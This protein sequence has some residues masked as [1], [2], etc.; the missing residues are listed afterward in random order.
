MRTNKIGKIAVGVSGHKQSKFN[1]SHDV[2]NTMNM[3]EVRPLIVKEM[4]PH[5]SIGIKKDNLIMTAPLNVFTYG[6]IDYETISHF[7]PEEKIFPRIGSFLSGEATACPNDPNGWESV[8]ETKPSTIAGILA[9]YMLIG[10]KLNV[11]SSLDP[12]D[13]DDDEQ[14]SQ[15]FFDGQ[16]DVQN[17]YKFKPIDLRDGLASPAKSLYV[18][19]I[20]DEGLLQYGIVGSISEPGTNPNGESKYF[21][22][23]EKAYLW[24]NLTRLNVLIQEKNAKAQ[25]SRAGLL[26]SNY[27]AHMLDRKLR[28]APEYG[29]DHDLWVPLS[30][31]VADA[32]G[33]YETYN[34]GKRWLD[35]QASKLETGDGS[36]VPTDIVSPENADVVIPY[37]YEHDGKTYL[38]F[39]C[40]RL[41]DAGKRFFSLLK[42]CEMPTDIGCVRPVNCEKLLAVYMAYFESFGLQTTDAVQNH[43]F[44]RLIEAMRNDMYWLEPQNSVLACRDNLCDASLT[45][46]LDAYNLETNH[47]IPA[48]LCLFDMWLTDGSDFASIH[49]N[50]AVG[51]LPDGSSIPSTLYELNKFVHSPT[52]G[53]NNGQF[54]LPSNAMPHFS[55]NA[56]EGTLGSL[57]Q[58]ASAVH[59]PLDERLL[60]KLA[61][62]TNR[63]SILGHDIEKTLKA[64]GYGEV[65]NAFGCE[66]IGKTSTRL[67][68]SQ[69]P[70]LADTYDGVNGKELGDIG[71]KSITYDDSQRLTYETRNGGY[72]IT[73]C[74]IRPVS[75][76]SQSVDCE[77][78]DYER[79]DVYVPEF[80]GLGYE[81]TPMS[82]FFN[83]ARC[84]SLDGVLSDP[85]CETFGVVP[86]DSHRKVTRDVML[87]GFAL[88]SVRNTFSPYHLSRFTSL[89]DHTKVTE[90]QDGLADF[91]AL[92]IGMDKPLVLRDIPRCGLWTRSPYRYEWLCQLQ[93]IFSNS[94]VSNFDSNLNT[95][96]Y[97]DFGSN[98]FIF[99]EDNF[100]IH[101]HV[102]GYYNAPM[103]PIEVSYDSFEEDKG[104]NGSETKA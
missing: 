1:I 43:P 50:S 88:P 15:F 68:I 65:Y 13:T 52:F 96:S 25:V 28:N 79:G 62:W 14:L 100:I 24:L 58:D 92:V 48:I 32:F 2:E 64:M 35:P 55:G 101:T 83:T 95:P 103:K 67:E 102:D 3:G 87:G 6:K 57:I 7:V 63:Q 93:R 10:S 99:S 77:N 36:Y 84:I 26:P 5:S 78:F 16:S 86:R 40:F 29:G 97:G 89:G 76:Y 56:V 42:A 80:D 51:M 11:W 45:R 90:R 12:V 73:L 71:A 53:Y 60:M 41:S 4:K 21:N 38:A 31:S 98:F 19:L 46:I 17:L 44:S 75:G 82:Q 70:S 104:A 37:H 61:K 54:V 47:V 69:C 8:P 39:C 9:S 91:N 59:S 22:N 30:N 20:E 94:Q 33:L 85:S 34:G 18:N 66:F 74:Y 27:Y 72:W 49:Q 81:N 23:G